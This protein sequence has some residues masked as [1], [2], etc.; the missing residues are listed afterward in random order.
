MHCPQKLEVKKLVFMVPHADWYHVIVRQSE[1]TN[2]VLSINC[3]WPPQQNK[4]TSA[5]VSLNAPVVVVD[6]V[7]GGVR[8]SWSQASKFSCYSWQRMPVVAQWW[9][10][11]KLKNVLWWRLSMFCQNGVT[12]LSLRTDPGIPT[13]RFRDP[14]SVL[15]LGQV[16]QYDN[17]YL[18]CIIDAPPPAP[19]SLS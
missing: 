2:G 10:Q 7:A 12:W 19:S 1:H 8:C 15:T 14:G 16:T 5:V 3:E 13:P 4:T 11:N 18:I 6:V 9:C 17:P